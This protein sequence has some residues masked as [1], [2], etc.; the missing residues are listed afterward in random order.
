MN[1]KCRIIL[2]LCIIFTASFI[3]SIVMLQYKCEVVDL[4]SAIFLLK[5]LLVAN[6]IKRYS[7]PVKGP[8]VVQRLGRGIAPLFNDRCTRSG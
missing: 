2:S 1:M 5:L 3:H 6:N 7:V 4:R 8:V